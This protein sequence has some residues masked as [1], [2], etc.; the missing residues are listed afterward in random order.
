MSHIVNLIQNL[1]IKKYIVILMNESNHQNSKIKI[2]KSQIFVCKQNSSKLI[3]DVNKNILLKIE[4][5]NHS[6]FNSINNKNVL[7]TQMSSLNNPLGLQESLV[8]SMND[9]KSFNNKV[10]IKEVQLSLSKKKSRLIFDKVK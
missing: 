2:R 3:Y 4:P 8:S 10:K 1:D 9:L 7:K 6:D 5:K